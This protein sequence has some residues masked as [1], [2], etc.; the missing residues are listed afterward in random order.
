MTADAL[1]VLEALFGTI[2]SLFTSWHIPGT[3]TTPAGWFVFCLFVVFCL[4][5]LKTILPGLLGTIS[6]G[7]GS[8][9]SSKSK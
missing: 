1:L 5:F 3:R 9:K 8:S 7:G 2:W 6:R 4:R